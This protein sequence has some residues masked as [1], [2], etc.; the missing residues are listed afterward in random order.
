MLNQ[1]KGNLETAGKLC[2]MFTCPC[3]I[4]SPDP[5]PT[6]PYGAMVP[7]P[8]QTLLA[9]HCVGLLYPVWE[10]PEGPTQGTHLYLRE[11]VTDET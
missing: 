1:E 9:N 8:E 6:S 5:Q 7:V 10:L 4:P 2:G 3:P 11:K